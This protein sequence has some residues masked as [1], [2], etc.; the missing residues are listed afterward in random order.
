MLDRLE[1]G[2]PLEQ[3]DET[4][5]MLGIP[6]EPD[7]AKRRQDK[8]WDLWER[9]IGI[10]ERLPALYR[11]SELERLADTYDVSELNRETVAWSRGLI[12]DFSAIPE[13]VA[14]RLRLYLEGRTDQESLIRP[15][16]FHHHDRLWFD[17]FRPI[18]IRDS[19]GLYSTTVGSYWPFEP[20]ER[21]AM[22]DLLR[23][24][25]ESFDITFSEQDRR[26]YAGYFEK[27]LL[28][29]YPL[30]AI[31]HAISKASDLYR[32]G[33]D[34]CRL[35]EPAELSKRFVDDATEERMTFL[36]WGQETL[37]WNV[38]TK[39]EFV[40]R[41]YGINPQPL[42][43]PEELAEYIEARWITLTASP[44]NPGQFEGTCMTLVN[45]SAGQAYLAAL[46]AVQW[47]RSIPQSERNA[48][49]VEIG[50][51]ARIRSEAR[52]IG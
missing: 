35:V 17:S 29:D 46:K 2:L 4:L 24:F 42:P 11:T 47:L 31:L 22:A 5:E 18:V 27:V 3:R 36:L 33:F 38:A 14:H 12:R 1:E 37:R 44:V 25:E 23:F 50:F 8:V 30:E 21:F 28:R 16:T 51:H 45:S 52:R 39:K 40:Q 7:E 41:F 6:R 20:V 48:L 10:P 26:K 43:S 49:G 15:G 13:E 34:E 19:S 9:R 32:D